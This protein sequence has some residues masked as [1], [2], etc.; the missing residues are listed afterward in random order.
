MMGIWVKHFK[1]GN[2]SKFIEITLVLGFSIQVEANY[3]VIVDNEENI[4]A[5]IREKENIMKII[6]SIYK[7]IHIGEKTIDIIRIVNAFELS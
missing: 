3:Y 4:L 6:N 2:N 1:D 5:R 7:D